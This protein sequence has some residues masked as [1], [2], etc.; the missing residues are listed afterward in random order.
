MVAVGVFKVKNQNWTPVSVD[1][2]HTAAGGWI[3]VH[4]KKCRLAD[5]ASGFFFFVCVYFQFALG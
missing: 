3:A 1:V 4:I 2:L 5:C